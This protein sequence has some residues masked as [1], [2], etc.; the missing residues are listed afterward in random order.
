MK[1]AQ[2][3]LIERVTEATRSKTDRSAR[4]IYLALKRTSRKS[5][6]PYGEGEASEWQCAAIGSD[7]YSDHVVWLG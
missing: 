1:L 2:K 3:T 6:T 5:C 4:F 7:D